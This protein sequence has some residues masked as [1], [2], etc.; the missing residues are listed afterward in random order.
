MS[1]K[2]KLSNKILLALIQKIVFICFIIVF[3]QYV[4]YIIVI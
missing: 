1:A 3:L 4:L 2:I